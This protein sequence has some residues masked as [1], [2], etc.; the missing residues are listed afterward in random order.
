MT[1]GLEN[2]HGA[3]R[4]ARPDEAAI[5]LYTDAIGAPELNTPRS[6]Q[7]KDK[8]TGKHGSDHHATKQNSDGHIPHL[9]IDHGHPMKGRQV[10]YWRSQLEDSA[11]H[12][13]NVEQMKQ[14]ERA[15]DTFEKRALHTNM[16][17]EQVAKFYSQVGR[18]LSGHDTNHVASP[19][20]KKILAL[21]VLEQAAQPDRITQGHHNTC[22]VACAE[23][24]VY[25]KH[26]E[27]A[28]RLIADQVLKGT[29]T[30][31]DGFTLLPNR[32]SM[33]PEYGSLHPPDDMTRTYASQVFQVT[34]VNVFWQKSAGNIE[35]ADGPVRYVQKDEGKLGKYS[36]KTG[37]ALTSYADGPKVLSSSPELTGGRVGDIY[38]EIA[39][40][41]DSKFIVSNRH[42]NGDSAELAGNDKTVMF[43]DAEQLAHSLKDLKAKGQFPVVLTLYAQDA[44]FCPGGNKGGWHA[45]NITSYD[46]STGL[47]KIHNPWGKS[48]DVTM[49]YKDLYQHTH[50]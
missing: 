34:A 36:D 13:L 5:R 26:P 12:K 29:Y 1:N 44:P 32:V 47:V 17:Q 2:L 6:G 43:N 18:I 31:K 38:N 50:R 33:K 8:H 39:G 46:S 25:S 16:S 11:H 21:Q 41:K 37:E 4:D 24:R 48:T 45:V 20:V 42:P 3:R 35:G 9:V 10:D 28:A 7:V 23:H 14:M 15:I 19:E 49:S 40:V 22:N 30:T 27:E